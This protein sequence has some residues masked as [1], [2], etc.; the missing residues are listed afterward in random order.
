M[1][2]KLK[3]ERHYDRVHA[4]LRK[5][6]AKAYAC[7]GKHCNGLSKSYHYALKHG[8]VHDYKRGNYIMLCQSCHKKYDMTE[9]TRIKMSNAKKGEKH[10]RSKLTQQQVDKIRTRYEF[11]KIT[12][13]ML[14]EEYSVC[15]HTI[16]YILK[17]RTWKN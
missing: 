16:H 2:L 8:Y 9:D 5:Q 11:R 7:H 17:G 4:W 14:A 1:K 13:K 15:E 10:S 12:Q 6:F 3:P